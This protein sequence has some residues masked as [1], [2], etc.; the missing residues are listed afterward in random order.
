MNLM[1]M[2]HTR[3]SYIPRSSSWSWNKLYTCPL[4]EF[5]ALYIQC[6]WILR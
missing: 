6:Q 5:M 2:H 1:S 4:A 3:A